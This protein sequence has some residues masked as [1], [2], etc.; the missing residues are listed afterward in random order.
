MDLS[1]DF[2]SIRLDNIDFPTIN[3]E[4]N[5][6]LTAIITGNEIK[7]VVWGCDGKK[8]LKTDGYNFNFLKRNW[9]VVS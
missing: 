2:L 7:E 1:C 4:N 8:C 9:R 6:F 3:S 5:L